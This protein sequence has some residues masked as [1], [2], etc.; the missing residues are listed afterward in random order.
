MGEVLKGV[1]EAAIYVVAYN[2]TVRLLIKG[3][4][5]L[6]AR[7]YQSARAEAMKNA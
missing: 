3:S 1:A 7:K 6:V 2:V 4:D 5:Y